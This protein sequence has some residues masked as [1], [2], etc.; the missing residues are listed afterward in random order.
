MSHQGKESGQSIVIIAFAIMM[1]LALVAIVV[2]VGNAYAHR[3][4]V[5][6]AVD[7]AALAGARK[8]A[9]RMVAT[10]P[11]S[12][13][14]IHVSYQIRR[15]AAEN[16]LPVSE[17]G[18]LQA[19][20]IDKS[21]NRIEQVR[22]SPDFINPQARGVEVIGKLPFTTY[23]AHLLGFSTMEAATS[24]R[25][26]VLRGPCNGD[27]LFPVAIAQS[28]F[29]D[30]GVPQPGTTYTMWDK[31]KEAPGQFGWLYWVDGNGVVRG[32]EPP[33]QN[34][35]TVNL[36]ANI[37]DASRSGAWRVNDWVC[38]SSGVSFQ[39]VLNELGQRMGSSYTVI[40]PIYD[41]V[42]GTG[43]N[44]VYRI[45]GFGAFQMTCAYS[46]K[47]QYVEDPSGSCAPCREQDQ[48][49]IRGKF[50][51]MIEPSGDDGCLD[52]GVVIPSFRMPK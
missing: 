11:D 12:V 10:N 4:I 28:V 37:L 21:G 32:T 31:T 29:G 41:Q 19:W 36:A 26:W 2:D 5:Q 9:D 33:R 1:L 45:V 51:R 13:K 14:H 18:V 46:S 40:V 43:N 8:L 20:F 48:P 7:A 52:T 35:N 23:F 50:V 47:N 34:S 6:N 25:A 42:T 30:G 22:P 44:T 39:P 38:G 16:G 49:C 3:R 15:Y 27:N 24:A 17:P